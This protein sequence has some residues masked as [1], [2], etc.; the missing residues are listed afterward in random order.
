MENFKLL[1]ID[2]ATD[3]RKGIS[4]EIY[5]NNCINKAY[6]NL[7]IL[8]RLAELG[9]STEDL[10]NT[11]FLRIRV[12]LEQNAPMWMFSISKQMKEKI[13]KVQKISVFI[14]L[15]NDAHSDYLCNLAILDI[16]PLE[17]RRQQIAT[18]LAKKILK[19]PEHR[20]MFKFKYD[21][22]RSK[23]KVLVP[24]SRTARYDN[25]PIPSLARLINLKLSHKI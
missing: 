2:L 6:K 8:R 18:N 5:I 21:K 25:S 19:H 9:I 23:K 17:E 15:G 16:E 24:P 3:K 14:I 13:E 22:T 7:Y 4:F 10:L 20:K 1:G 11:Y 12:C